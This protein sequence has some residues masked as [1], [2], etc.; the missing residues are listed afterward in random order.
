MKYARWVRRSLVIRTD[1]RKAEE[2]DELVAATLREMDNLHIMVC[3]AGV[4]GYPKSDMED[5]LAIEN[6]KEEDWNMAIDVNLK[7]V[8]LCCRAVARHFKKQKY[9]KIINIA[10][11]SG[12]RGS[13]LLAYSAS[14]GGVMILSQAIALQM[15]P[16]NVNVNTICPGQIWSPIW[17]VYLPVR[18]K[19]NPA[20]EGMEAREIFEKMTKGNT[21]LGRPQTPE[22]VGNAVVFLA[23]EEAREITGQAINVDG[24][25]IFS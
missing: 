13:A 7:G 10:S 6:I 9:G 11:S 20:Y 5:F 3:N 15:A 1:V 24:G 25:K 19:D 14:K 2:C 8:F 22:D 23:S 4:G 18:Y 21:P 17:D 16:Y 12:R